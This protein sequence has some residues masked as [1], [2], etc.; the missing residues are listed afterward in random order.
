MAFT[1][2]HDA[3]QKMSYRTAFSKI[4]PLFLRA[5]RSA[6]PRMF[7]VFFIVLLEILSAVFACAEQ[8]EHNCHR[9]D[10][11]RAAGQDAADDRTAFAGAP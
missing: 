1:V 3:R 11:D 6:F 5:Y 8:R 10:R 4:R 9:A 7:P 2:R